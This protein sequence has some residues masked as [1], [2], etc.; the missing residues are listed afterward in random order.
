[1][2]QV[3]NI[4]EPRN[5]PVTGSRASSAERESAG[6]LGTCIFSVD[7]EDWFHILDLPTTPAITE[8]DTLPSRV[9]RNFLK[10]LDILGEQGARVTC[11]VL[12]WVAQKYPHLVKQAEALGHEI[13]S[14][15]Y[16]HKL[17]YQMTPDE[18]FHDARVSKEALESLVGHAIVGYRAA[19]FS[20]NASTAWFYE[21]LVE[22][23]YSYDSSVFPAERGHGGMRYGHREPHRVNCA[24]GTIV[25][26]P[27]TVEPILGK[28][29]CFFG[30]GYLRL[31]PY[32]VTKHMTGKVL[33]AGRPVIFYV[34]PREIDPEHPRLEMN[35]QRRFKSYV[36]LRS[37]EAKIRRLLSDFQVSSFQEFLA[38]CPGRLLPE[39]GPEATHSFQSETV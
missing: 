20:V 21:K 26:F 17:I 5:P 35:L 27:M 3:S 37:T 34:H 7:V 36:N 13:A 19:G 12:G 25:E 31:F 10:L 6:R 38:Q 2:N 4:T 9:E 8:W 33:Q 1:M 24:A 16:A 28:P 29:I 32:A 22:A 30:G 23:G 39:V 15:G 18:F 14:H 11:F